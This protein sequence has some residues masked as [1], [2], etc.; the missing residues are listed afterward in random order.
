M[1]KSKPIS[2][3]CQVNIILDR[4]GANGNTLRLE[5]HTSHLE[6][7]RSNIENNS[8]RKAKS[9]ITK[10]SRDILAERV[11]VATESRIRFSFHTLPDF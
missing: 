5:S 4:A 8:A 11:Q 6:L 1:N 3:I 7:V 2:L 10:P 9:R